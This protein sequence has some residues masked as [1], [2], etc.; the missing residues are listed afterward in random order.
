MSTWKHA[1][2]DVVD[3]SK[4]E[5][6]RTM[7]EDEVELPPPPAVEV[8]SLELDIDD[9][10]GGDPYNCTGQFCV[11]AFDKRDKD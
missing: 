10:A 4:D 3:E 1:D 9:D 8:T 6:A 5:L 11:P 2:D 7:A